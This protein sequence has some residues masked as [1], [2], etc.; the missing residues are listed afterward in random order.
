MAARIAPGFL[1]KR[2]ARG[3]DRYPPRR[4]A[5]LSPPDAMAC[6][7]AERHLPAQDGALIR[8]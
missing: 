5:G 8:G 6:R 4:L 7:G 2:L 1:V 3:F